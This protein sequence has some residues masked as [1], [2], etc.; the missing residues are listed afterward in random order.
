MMS[1]F[2]DEDR[3]REA[4][5]LTPLVFL[6]LVLALAA[7]GLLQLLGLGTSPLFDADAGPREVVARGDLAAD[8][9]ATID[10]FREVSSSVVHIRSSE[11]SGGGRP[12]GSTEMP[13]GSGSG[14]MWSDQGYIVTNFHVVMEG[15]RWDVV[16]A[17]RSMHEARLVGYVAR[18]DLAV[19]K[20][21]APTRKLRPVRVG[22]SRELLVGQKVF[23]VGSP[24]GVQ[25]DRTL[26]TGVISGLGRR[27][28]GIS[29]DII[30]GV[31][32]TD[33]AINP[34][35]SGGPLFDSSARLIGVNT[36]IE[37]EGQGIG[38]AVPVDTV[39]AVVPMII[40]G[41]AS[42]ETPSR[43]GLGVLIASD[44]FTE[45]QGLEGVVV[46]EVLEES[47]AER[48][49]LRSLSMNRDGSYEADVLR[50]IDGVELRSNHD[51]FVALKDR[52]PGERVDLEFER[53]GQRRRVQLALDDLSG[54]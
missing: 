21:D 37:A 51:L 39:N 15:N 6:G 10:L 32:Q 9:Q 38:F 1:P 53:D 52:A 49:G 30:E 44:S 27:I 28:K 24:F 33:A 4:L 14:F 41:G 36:A 42:S 3:R 50:S 43:A 34:G 54:R 22:T 8:E 16:L 25:L 31:I 7:Y 40:S 18:Y 20:I 2:K 26:T 46:E 45:L 23:A 19:L 35:N 11:V 48:A 12:W 13:R 17:D 47:A 29:G 5:P